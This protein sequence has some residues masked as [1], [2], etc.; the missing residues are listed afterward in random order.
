MDSAGRA[1]LQPGTLPDFHASFRGF[2]DITQGAVLNLYALTVGNL[3]QVC[4][5]FARR[6]RSKNE[7]LTARQDRGRYFMPFRGC[8]NEDNMR[9]GLL[10]NFQQRVKGR[11]RKHV[12]FINDEDLVPAARGRVLGALA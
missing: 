9:R 3:S 5:D 6:D 1:L 11:S 7:L 10:Q 2:H 12:D 8:H 4:V